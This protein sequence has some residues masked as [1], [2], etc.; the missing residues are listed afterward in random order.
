MK[1]EVV[2]NYFKSQSPVWS[3]GSSPN[4][5]T[6]HTPFDD[7]QPESTTPARVTGLPAALI[8]PWH[9]V[10]NSSGR[11]GPGG[12]PTHVQSLGAGAVWKGAADVCFNHRQRL[13]FILTRGA[14]PTKMPIA[15]PRAVLRRRRLV[16][17]GRW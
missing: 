15:R 3:Y 11:C 16:A 4:L 13:Q 10:C 7:S 17:D 2:F 6:L 1:E 14:Q 12:L 8:V 5:R 9:R